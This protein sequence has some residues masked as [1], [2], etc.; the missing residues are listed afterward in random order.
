MPAMDAEHGRNS[1]TSSSSCAGT[2]VDGG[3]IKDLEA[4]NAATS[5]TATHN[6]EKMTRPFSS[7]D[8][9]VDWDGPDDPE[10]P[11]NWSFG[12]KVTMTAVLSFTCLVCTFA[13]SIFSTG[14]AAAGR[15]FGIG[16]EVMELGM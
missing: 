9:L 13:S 6:T 3:S 5:F 4:Q 14:Q 10:N 7:D 15:E 12:R 16:E 2:P 1:I 8:Y 11:Q